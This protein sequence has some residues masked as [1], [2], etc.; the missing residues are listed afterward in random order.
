[1]A[2]DEAFRALMADLVLDEPSDVINVRELG[3]AEIIQ[4]LSRI[5]EELGDRHELLNPT[6][7][8]SRELHS[9][10]TAY[11]LEMKRRTETE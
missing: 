8:R 3:V 4:G 2:D 7:D 11:R 6:T 1:V 5:N 10:R 9:L